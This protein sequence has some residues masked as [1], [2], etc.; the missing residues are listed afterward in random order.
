MH[1]TNEVFEGRLPKGISWEDQVFNFCEFRNVQGEGLHIA[2]AFLDCTF[3][4]CDLYW[5]LANIATFV[6]VKFQDCQFRGCSFSGCRF[7]ECAFEG[8][9]FMDDN[10]GGSC[11]FDGSRWY[12]CKQNGTN[13]LSLQFAFASLPP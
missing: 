3:T 11:N 12:G 9:C 5:T 8:C 13:G 6:G 2:S 1:V 4:Q 10:L 7:V